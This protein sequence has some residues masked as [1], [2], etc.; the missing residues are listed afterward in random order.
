LL[1]ALAAAASARVRA[2]TPGP[3]RIELTYDP[4]RQS[5]T[6]NL[7]PGTSL[8]TVGKACL[9]IVHTAADLHPLV[10]IQRDGVTFR[11]G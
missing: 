5:F 3:V 4:D 8:A 2:R 7:A 10:N 1:P 9:A 6:A 11:R